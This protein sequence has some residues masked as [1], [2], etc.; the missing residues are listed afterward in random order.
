MRL[1]ITIFLF[2]LSVSPAFG[3]AL[4]ADHNATAQFDQIPSNIIANITAGYK[5]Y[6]GHTSHGSQVI[7]GIDYIYGDNNLYASPVFHEVADD[8]GSGGDTTWAADIRSWLTAHP[9][10]N[11]VMMSWCGGVSISTEADI[12][13]YLDKMNE[14]ENQFVT[15]NFVYMT[16]HLD[17]TG[18]TGTL[19]QNNNVIR[20]YCSSHNKVLYDFADIESYDPDSTYYP[21]ESDACNWCYDW[22]STHTCCSGTC[23]HSHC[24][25][26]YRKGQAWWWMMASL[27]GWSFSLDVNEQH[28]DVMPAQFELSQNYPNPFNPTTLFSFSVPTASHV[29]LDVYNV[30]GQKVA[31]LADD[32]YKAGMYSVSWD[33]AKFAS[34]VYFYKMDAGKYSEVKKMVLLK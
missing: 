3:A 16:G 25:N 13:V 30:S 34:G 9:D 6:Y 7:S 11:M 22:C 2:L 32:Y 19:Y 18:P 28:S 1:V 24:F 14:L 23:A 33:A 21:D 31:T 8:L 15:V 27:E 5:I 17:G 10:Y 29:V 12:N 20:A 26:C 4:I